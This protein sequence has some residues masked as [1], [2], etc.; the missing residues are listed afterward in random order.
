[1]VLWLLLAGALVAT[2]ARAGKGGNG[3]GGKPGG[4]DPPAD[5]EIAYVDCYYKGGRTKCDV[6]VMNADGSNDVIILKEAARGLQ[7]EI[8]TTPE[9]S[10]SPD[11]W[12]NGRIAYNATVDGEYALRVMDEDGSNSVPLLLLPSQH[13]LSPAWSPTTAPDG[14][15]WIAYSSRAGGTGA[16]DLFLIS[17]DGGAP[18]S[19]P[20]AGT[21]RR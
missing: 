6:H 10:W 5:P 11:P 15:E 14:V 18:T 2:D 8:V 13:G 19:S 9:V 12:P 20:W 17:P 3:G 4:G 21:G 7:F 16:Y 1:V